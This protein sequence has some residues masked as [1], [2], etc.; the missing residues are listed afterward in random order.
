MKLEPRK[1]IKYIDVR[2]ISGALDFAKNSNPIVSDDDVVFWSR[3]LVC[4]KITSSKLVVKDSNVTSRQF[5]VSKPYSLWVWKTS[6]AGVFID[7]NGNKSNDKMTKISPDYQVNGVIKASFL[8]N[9]K[10]INDILSQS[11][12]GV[13][14]AVITTFNSLSNSLKSTLEDRYGIE[15]SNFLISFYDVN[16]AARQRIS[17]QVSTGGASLARWG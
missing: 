1:E 11:A 7:A 13:S 14:G 16:D 9:V 4:E 2:I 15:S 10:T 12:S 3:F 6:T 8:Q 5:L 17:S